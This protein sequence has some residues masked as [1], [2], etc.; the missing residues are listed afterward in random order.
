MICIE[1]TIP[2]L[3]CVDFQSNNR[4]AST[5][6][7]YWICGVTSKPSRGENNLS[8]K[9]DISK[10][11]NWKLW[12]KHALLHLEGALTADGFYNGEAI[13]ETGWH[14]HIQPYHESRN[15]DSGISIL[16]GILKVLARQKKFASV[17]L[18]R[19]TRKLSASFGP[20]LYDS[21]NP[22]LVVTLTPPPDFQKEGDT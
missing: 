14:I 7:K 6:K 16:H 8:L 1:T 4:Y 19:D 11:L 2:A 9:N 13:A 21:Q 17:F 18:F 5:V 3:G 12:E 15:H 10:F 22:R 20:P